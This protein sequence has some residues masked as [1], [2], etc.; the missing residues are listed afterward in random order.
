M[1]RYRDRKDTKAA[2]KMAAVKADGMRAAAIAANEVD[3]ELR[4]PPS[5][6]TG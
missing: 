6:G 4:P 3:C 5:F 2:K 1:F